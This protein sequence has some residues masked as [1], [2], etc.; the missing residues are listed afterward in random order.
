MNQ[1]KNECPYEEDHREEEEKAKEELYVR[2]LVSGYVFLPPR[3]EKK[4]SEA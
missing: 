2:G 3:V 1:K 4:K